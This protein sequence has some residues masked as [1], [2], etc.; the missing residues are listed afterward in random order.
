MKREEERM[1]RVNGKAVGDECVFMVK[2]RAGR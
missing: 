2:D 1:E